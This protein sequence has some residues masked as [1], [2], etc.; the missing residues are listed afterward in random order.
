ML[1]DRKALMSIENIFKWA[2]Q[3]LCWPEAIHPQTRGGCM[4]DGDHGWAHFEVMDV[5]K[6]LQKFTHPKQPKPQDTPHKWN[7]SQQITEH[8]QR[9]QLRF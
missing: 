3:T 7:K 5:E 2:T 8:L 6:S 9:H 1:N 4:G